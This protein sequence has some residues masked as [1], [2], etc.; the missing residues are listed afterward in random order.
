MNKLKRLIVLLFCSVF[1]FSAQAQDFSRN[2]Q[3]QQRIIQAKLF[4]IKN[5]LALSDATAKELAPIYRRYELEKSEVQFPNQGRLLRT[6]P[7]S[8]STE[9]AD[10]L[11]TAQLD[12]SIRLST[13]RKKY[14]SEFRTVLTPQQIIKLFKSEAQ[15]NKKVMQELRRRFNNRMSN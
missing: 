5:A 9:E 3:L 4:E 1:W 10:K 12:N 8:L 7:D 15:L 11:I 14:Y 6:N 2:P 13:I